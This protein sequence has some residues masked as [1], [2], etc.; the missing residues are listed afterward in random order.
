MPK[1]KS[2]SKTPKKRK[3]K[4]GS[5]K[6]RKARANFKKKMHEAKMM[7]R[8]QGK[9]SGKKTWRECIKDAFKKH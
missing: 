8:K 3:T 6:S 2:H 9:G 5:E 1:V 4:K 7:Y